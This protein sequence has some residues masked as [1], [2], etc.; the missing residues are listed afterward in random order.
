MVAVDPVLPSLRSRLERLGYVVVPHGDYLCVRLALFSSVRV[1]ERGGQLE[2]RP[3]FGPFG[4]TGGLL[5]TSAITAGAVGGS[6][7]AL[8]MAPLTA[9]VAF[10][11][12]VGLAHDACRFVVTEGAMTR[13]QL[14]AASLE[15]AGILRGDARERAALAAAG[16]GALTAGTPERTVQRPETPPGL[17]PPSR[18]TLP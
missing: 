17:R 6:A 9:V 11:G 1:Y 15:D 3:R 10:L 8:G 16:G 7:F 18:R 4:R 2:L 14:L 12:V 13:L 5:A